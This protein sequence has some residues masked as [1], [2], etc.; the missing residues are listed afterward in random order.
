MKRVRIG[1]IGCG[2]IAQVHHMPN[3]AELQDEFEV[4][5]VCDVSAGAAAYVAN[6][7][8]VGQHFTDYRDL[9]KTDVEAVLL[10]HSDP[11]TEIA[12]ASFD[13]GKHVLIEKPVCYSLQEMDSIMAAQKRVGTVGQAAY[14]KVFDPAFELAKG[15]VDTMENIQFVQINHLHPNNDL[16]VRQFH[17]ERFDDVPADVVAATVAARKKARFQAIGDVPSHVER[18]FH[19]L[20]GS[21]I[22]DLYG[23]RAMMGMP[24]HVVSTEIWREGRGVTLTLAYEDG[25]RC[26][27]TW[28]DLP[29]LWDFQETL[30]VYGDDKRVIIGY[31]T[32]FSRGILSTVSIQGI[33]DNGMTYRK[34]PAID[35]ESAFK[36]ELRHF[37]KCIVDG[38]ACR[39][40]LEDA[41]LDVGLIIDITKAYPTEG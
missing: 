19:L 27:A 29:K 24:T 28:V 1:V 32:G 41:R 33:D 12:V 8:H 15:E 40:P 34:E 26:V 18:A 39:T 13:A 30:E 3:L 6:R 37:H 14:M 11:K 36:R 17:M 16:H 2:A 35:W 9:L 38:I 4:T 21:M 23:L 25:A 7:F 20:A 31:P 10:C 22:H 5:A